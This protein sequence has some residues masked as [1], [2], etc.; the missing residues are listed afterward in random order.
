MELFQKNNVF[1]EDYEELPFVRMTCGN[2]TVGEKKMKI[3]EKLLLYPVF[4]D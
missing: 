3:K 1:A 2:F 4:V